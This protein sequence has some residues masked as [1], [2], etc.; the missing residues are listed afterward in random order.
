[1][2]LKLE[3]RDYLSSH[4]E[5]KL[6]KESDFELE[7]VELRSVEQLELDLHL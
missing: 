7:T 3:R 2:S 4:L 1:M 6:Y 5:L